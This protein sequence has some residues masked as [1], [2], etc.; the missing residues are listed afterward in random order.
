MWVTCSEG[1][2]R[3]CRAGSL[4]YAAVITA[5]GHTLHHQED[6]CTLAD[7]NILSN[8]LGCIIADYTAFGDH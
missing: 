7:Y 4:A 2:S 6:G 1:V 3:G 5:P 8:H